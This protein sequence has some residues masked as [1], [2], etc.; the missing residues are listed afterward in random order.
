MQ[1]VLVICPTNRDKRELFFDHVRGNYNIVFHEYDASQL[2]QIVCKGIG[3]LLEDFEPQRM[4]N[5][6][7]AIAAK[8]NI[9]GVLSTEDYPGSIFASIVAEKLDLPGSR[10]KLFLCCQHKYYSR[11]VQQACVSEATSQFWLQGEREEAELLSFSLLVKRVKSFFLLLFLCMPVSVQFAMQDGSPAVCGTMWEFREREC[12]DCT[13]ENASKIF[14]NK[15]RKKKCRHLIMVI[16][17]E[18]GKGAPGSPPDVKL[19][20]IAQVKSAQ[21]EVLRSR[22]KN[23]L[24]ELKLKS[25]SGLGLTV[26]SLR[27]SSYGVADKRKSQKKRKKRRSLFLDKETA[28]RARGKSRHKRH[29]SICVSSRENGKLWMKERDTISSKP[30]ELLFAS[31]TKARED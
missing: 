4:I 16:G 15:F 1:N 3:R 18:M 6:I 27:K 9:D 31:T 25:V 19:P 28:H 2:E 24:P 13:K 20:N 11:Y 12:P 29:N 10:T 14:V 30:V 22:K 21:E 5:N 26:K 17:P 23:S 8:N 7:L